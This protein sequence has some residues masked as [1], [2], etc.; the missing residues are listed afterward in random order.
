MPGTSLGHGYTAALDKIM[1]F[2]WA[3]WLVTGPLV[4]SMESFLLDVRSLTTDF[5]IES[6]MA[7][8]RNILRH[9]AARVNQT[10]SSYFLRFEYLFPLAVYLPDWNHTCMNM[11]K[12]ILFELD[13]WPTVLAAIRS[14]CQFF[15]VWEYRSCLRQAMIQAGEFVWADALKS[16][17]A[18]MA[19]WRY[20]T[21]HLVFSSLHKLRGFCELLFDASILGNV[22]DASLVARTQAACKDASLWRFP[23][24]R[25]I[26]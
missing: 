21:V 26:T 13:R 2:L 6:L 15:R 8:Y 10:V 19:H 7:D 20:E 24:N 4:S 3:L 22:E 5:G 16:F 1:A 23:C 18:S 14:L 17:S 11:V 25:S 12:R 9:F